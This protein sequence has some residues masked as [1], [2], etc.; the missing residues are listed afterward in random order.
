[1]ADLEISNLYDTTSE[2]TINGF[3]D[4]MKST[5]RVKT[6]YHKDACDYDWLE[7]FE[8]TI[9]HIDK[10]LRNPK[11]FI[12]TD[13]E[14]VKIELAKKITV[15]SIKHLSKHTNFIQDVDKKTGDVKPSKILNVLKEETFNTYE[16]RFVFTLI[17]YMLEF[18]QRK[19]NISVKDPRLKDNK[20]VE[21]TSSTLVGEEKVNVNISLNTELDT[22]LKNEDNQKRIEKLEKD[23]NNLMCSE[24][25]KTLNK[26]GVPLVT[27]PIRKTNIILKNVDFQYAMKLWTYIQEH[28]GDKNDPTKKSRNYMETGNL[29]KLIDE[30]FLLEYLTVNSINHDNK[31]TEEMKERTISRMLDKIIDMNPDLTKRE[32]QNKLGAQFDAVKIRRAASKIDIEKIFRKHIDKYLKQISSIKF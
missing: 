32:L 6:D 27:N 26:E 28:L 29:K 16:N 17:K 20:N 3:E 19:K 14:I 30:T 22:S 2:E 18:I 23:I 4:Q 25:Y 31:V 21:Y 5:M 15:D 12:V 8:T 7:I 9:P 13:E 11:K 24:V 1:M 10:I